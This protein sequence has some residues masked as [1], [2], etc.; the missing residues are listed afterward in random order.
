MRDLE[1]RVFNLLV[2]S[3]SVAANHI[4]IKDELL[5]TLGKQK[6]STTGG[7]GFLMKHFLIDK[8]IVELKEAALAMRSTL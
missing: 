6:G 8:G 3:E 5:H 2:K 4:A 1:V 7:L